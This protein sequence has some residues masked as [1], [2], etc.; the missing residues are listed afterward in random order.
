MMHIISK[1][2]GFSILPRMRMRFGVDQAS[3]CRL[4]PEEM[5]HGCQTLRCWE[6][7]GDDG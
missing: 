5:M 1:P 2:D 6:D 4:A 3:S 7:D